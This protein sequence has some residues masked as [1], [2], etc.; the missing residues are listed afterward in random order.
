MRFIGDFLFAII[1]FL[2]MFLR[3]GKRHKEIVDIEYLGLYN[4]VGRKLFLQI[5]LIFLVGVC[6]V[7]ALAA[8]I[9]L[10]IKGV[11]HFIA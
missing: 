9:Y 7:W 5:M 6:G 8:I 1:G 2:Y 11:K 4:M 3:Y 10:V